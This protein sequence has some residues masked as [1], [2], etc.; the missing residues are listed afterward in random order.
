MPKIIITMPITLKKLKDLLI[1]PHEIL[2]KIAKER[3]VNEAAVMLVIN[4]V[5][6]S[7]GLALSSQNYSIIP[8]LLVF[9]IIATLA[10]SFLIQ[11]SLTIIGG[12]GDYSSALAASTY[13][14]F[15][16]ALS[17]LIVSIIF[18]WSDKIATILG[19]FLFVL[20][21]TVA[22]TGAFRVLKES[23]KVDIITVWIVTS[24][25]MLAIFGSMY[26]MIAIYILKVGT[27]PMLLT[28][29]A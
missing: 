10:A 7:T 13:P 3:N 22:L 26:I 29:V 2:P 18:F 28:A 15:G 5:L 1:S 23:F 17:S 16:L 8:A 24:L 27:T 20:Y 6:I 19:T 21:L 11:L 9:G 25:L 14:F 12:K 4:W